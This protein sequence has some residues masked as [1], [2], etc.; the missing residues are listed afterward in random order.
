[1][2]RTPNIQRFY[3]DLRAYEKKYGTIDIDDLGPHILAAQSGDEDARDVIV[4]SCLRFIT[5]FT[6]NYLAN[7]PANVTIDQEFG[8][9]VSLS[10]LAI[11]NVIKNYKDDGRSIK[12]FLLFTLR[13]MFR[14]EVI[15]DNQALFYRT[16]KN[17]KK[18]PEETFYDTYYLNR[19]KLPDVASARYL[20]Q[21]LVR[22]DSQV[23]SN[24]ERSYTLEDVL[25]LN[26]SSCIPYSLGTLLKHSNL[27]TMERDALLAYFR[28]SDHTPDYYADKYQCSL[29]T[30][31]TRKDD[32]LKKLRHTAK[33]LSNWDSLSVLEEK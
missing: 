25:T 24:D 28:I 31:R 10:Y 3:N 26:D 11:D 19:D 6:N 22:L 21:D 20:A 7:T 8:D 13:R 30:I 12:L 18:H 5:Y 33:L 16:V 15:G 14:T 17:L 29:E 32:A 9:F 27:K 1:M 23:D 2:I 4:A